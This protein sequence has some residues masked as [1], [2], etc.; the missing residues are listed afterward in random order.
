MIERPTLREWMEV[1][2]PDGG[3]SAITMTDANS[4]GGG[5]YTVEGATAADLIA[6][7]ISLVEHEQEQEMSPRDLLAAA[8]SRHEY[9]TNTWPDE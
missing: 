5:I 7:G 1:L 6:I 8:V 2:T 4:D 9:R 3:E